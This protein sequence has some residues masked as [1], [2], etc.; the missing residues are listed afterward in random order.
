MQTRKAISLIS[1][2]LISFPLISLYAQSSEVDS[3]DIAISEYTKAIRSDPGNAMSY[4]LRG[5]MYIGKGDFKR[6][7]SDFNKAMEINPQLAVAYDGRGTAYHYMG[8][9]DRAI[10]DYNKA[11]EIEPEFWEAYAHRGTAYYQKDKKGNL[12]QALSDYTKAIEIEPGIA[13]NYYS[14]ANLYFLKKD[15][16]KSWEDVN[17]ATGLKVRE[18]VDPKFLE[19][20]KKAS[21]REK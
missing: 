4:V 19:S 16:D 8:E 2:I 17:K 15:Y 21:G 11:I 6:A 9:L 14:R 18:P 20:L 3:V 12:E 7:I 5:M 1:L 10:L 13:S